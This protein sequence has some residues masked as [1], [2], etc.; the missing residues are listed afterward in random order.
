MK[1]HQIP[2]AGDPLLERMAMAFTHRPRPRVTTFGDPFRD[3]PEP[4]VADRDT[5][6]SQSYGVVQGI[7]FD[8][9]EPAVIV[10]AAIYYPPGGWMGWH[11]NSAVPGWRVY[12][13]VGDIGMMLTTDGPVLDRPGHANIFHVP[14]WHAICARGERWSL[15]VLLP[16]G[17]RLVPT[18]G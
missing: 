7:D 13:P 11:T 3:L 17:H 9:G 2:I 10:R 16:E 8:P 12:V 6:L 4:P 15:G 14:A 18:A 5:A 1:V